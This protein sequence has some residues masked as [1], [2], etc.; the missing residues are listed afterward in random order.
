ML[1]DEVVFQT[2]VAPP[3]APPWTTDP[4]E[5]WNRVELAEPRKDAQIAR[6]YRAPLP[7]GLAV[8]QAR[9]VHWGRGE[10]MMK[11]ECKESPVPAG[12]VIVDIRQQTARCRML[13]YQS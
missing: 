10:Q 8:E 11:T 9:W 7:L 5:L 3:D 13:L 2:T 1:R 12:I 4:Q 6:D